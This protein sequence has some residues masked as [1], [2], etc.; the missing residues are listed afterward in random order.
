[1]CR[2]GVFRRTGSSARI[3]YSELDILERKHS[4]KVLMVLRSCGPVNKSE[5]T[6]SITSGAGS[7][8]VRIDDLKSSGLVEVREETV[9]PFRKM[10]SLTEKGR[11][12]ADLVAEIYGEL[13]S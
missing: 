5:L 6:E 9:R 13:S 12:V 7:V 3:P 10:V 4:L 8:Q 2:N 1:M 11:A